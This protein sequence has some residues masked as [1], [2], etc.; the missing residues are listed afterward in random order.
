MSWYKCYIRCITEV[1]TVV[2]YRRHLLKMEGPLTSMEHWICK[3]KILCMQG[4]T[5]CICC[6]TATSSSIGKA[7]GFPL[8]VYR[9]NSPR[10]IE[11]TSMSAYTKFFMTLLPCQASASTYSRVFSAAG[12]GYPAALSTCIWVCA[13]EIDVEIPVV[14]TESPT[15][16]PLEQDGR[17]KEQQLW[18]QEEF[19]LSPVLHNLRGN[20]KTTVVNET[21]AAKVQQ[22]CTILLPIQLL[23]QIISTLE[24]HGERIGCQFLRMIKTCYKMFFI[25]KLKD[26]Q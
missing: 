21:W 7:T 23:F 20:K 5:K 15:T 10:S 6:W 1:R 22:V 19:P 2:V 16:L 26:E 14:C 9:Y 3:A 8:L 25:Q 12:K 11:F 17:E 13:V 24:M 18:F 4:W